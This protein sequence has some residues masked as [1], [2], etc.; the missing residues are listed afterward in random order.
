MPR[1]PSLTSRELKGVRREHFIM[2]KK[3]EKICRDSP[4]VHPDM[5]GMPCVAA[6]GKL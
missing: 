4:V 2:A 5:Y 1:S 3:M 6:V